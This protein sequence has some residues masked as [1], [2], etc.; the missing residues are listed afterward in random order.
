MEYFHN[1]SNHTNRRVKSP[2]NA[3]LPPKISAT[4]YLHAT[5]MYDLCST[6]TV[7]MIIR[8][9]VHTQLDP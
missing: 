9:G 8:A 6:K 7:W 2:G 5:G 3:V 1:L 4:G